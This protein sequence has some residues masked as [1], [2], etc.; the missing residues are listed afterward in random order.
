MSEPFI[1]EIRMF[2]GNFAPRDWAYCNGQLMA[3]ADYNAL[4]AIIGTYYGGD[5]RSTFAL[6]D[7]RS[8]VPVGVGTG[9]GLMPYALAQRGGAESVILSQAQ[10]PAH[11]H[12][13][14][15]SAASVLSG[16]IDVKIPVNSDEAEENSAVNH[17]LAP[18]SAPAYAGDKTAGQYLGATEVNSTQDVTTSVNVEI[19]QTGAS[20]PLYNVQPYLGMHYII[21]LEGIFPPRP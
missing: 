20:Q 1:G 15:A 18:T 4:F 11:S 8:R 5:G 10:M 3:I 13:V 17:Y 16:N 9:P 6:P 21:C 7:L 12:S 14:Q 2:A 19:G